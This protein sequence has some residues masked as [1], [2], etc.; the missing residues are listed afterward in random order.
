[1]TITLDIRP[2]VEAELVRQA[3]TQGRAIEAVAAALLEGAVHA[4]PAEEDNAPSRAAEAK[5]LVELSARV[6]GLLTDNEIDTLFARNPSLSR[7]IDLS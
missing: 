7:P 6:R 5:D 2:E 1:M 3:A 4:R